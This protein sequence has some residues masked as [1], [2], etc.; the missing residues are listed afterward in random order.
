[1]RLRIFKA[2][3]GDCLLLTGADGRN[4]LIDGGMKDSYTEHVSR[5]LSGL[6]RLDALYVSH[7]D[8][9]HV[10]GLLRMMDDHVDWRVHDFQVRNGNPT[11]PEP[12]SRRPPPVAKIWQNAF[13]DQIGENAGDIQDML[14]AQAQVLS[15]HESSVIQGLALASADL[16]SSVGDA[17]QL[18]HRISPDQLDIPINPE[19]GGGMMFHTTPAE[20]LSVGGMRFTVIGPFEDDLKDLRREWNKWLRDQRDFV[21][22]LRRRARE[23]ARRLATSELEAF[24]APFLADAAALANADQRV[25]DAALAQSSGPLGRRS[26]VTVPNLASLMFHVRE[27]QRTMLLTGDG[28]WQDV[29]DGLR[30][31]GLSRSDG[32]LHVNVLKVPHHGSEHNTSPDFCKAITADH[33]VFCGN[34]AHENPDLR[35]VDAYIDSRIGPAARRSSNPEVGRRF[36]LWFNYHPDNEQPGRSGVKHRAHLR[37]LARRV[38]SRDR[39]SRQ[40]GATFLTGS[41]RTLSV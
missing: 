14:S 38:R 15:G 28:H 2:D 22:R 36:R 12:D 27:G 4:V 21:A 20:R 29:L 35:V 31:A 37:E 26:R 5:T 41:S 10:Y 30:L 39:R 9:D 13:H 25:Q 34:G 7:I 16:A 18:S 8:R 33:Y 24:L 6:R 11:H 40:M 3:K 19:F 1:M 23:D 32:T 17:I